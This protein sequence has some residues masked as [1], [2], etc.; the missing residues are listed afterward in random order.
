MRKLFSV[1]CVF[2]GVLPSACGGSAS[3]SV[4]A[5]GGIE[6]CAVS[7]GG[8]SDP[9]AAGGGTGALSVSTARECQWTAASDVS[10]LALS[11]VSGQGPSSISVSAAANRSTASRRST[12]TVNGQRVDVMQ[13]AATCQITVSPQALNVD[14]D[15]G[16]PSLSLTTQ[17]F[18]AWSASSRATWVT[19]GG[20]G[21]GTGPAG[22]SL[23]VAPNNGPA[24]TAIVDV[25]GHEISV[26]QAAAP[27]EC[28]FVIAPPSVAV[29]AGGTTTTI[30]VTGPPA[31]VWAAVTEAP[32]I[33]VV[34][35]STGGGSGSVALQVATNSGP[36]RTGQVTVAGRPLTVTQAAAA[37]NCSYSVAPVTASAG[38]TGGSLTF[39]VTAG[40]SCAWSAV[41]T[42]P[43]LTVSSN[44]NGAGNGPVT[45][46]VAANPG[47][48]RTGQLLIAGSTVRVD[49]AAAAP[50]PP[51]CSFAIG[52]TAAQ[53]PAAGGTTSTSVNTTAGCSW[54]ASSAASW[55]VVTSGATGSGPGTVTF[56][57]DANTGSERTGTATAAGLTFTVTQPAA[58]CAFSI[59]PSAHDAPAAGGKTT[60]AVS[61]AGGCAWSTTGAPAWVSV[62]NGNGSGNGTVTLDMQPNGGAARAATILIAGESF[63]VNQAGGCSVGIDPAGHSA[64]AEAGTTTVTVTTS[65]GCAWSTTGVPSWITV[66]NGSGSG[67]GIVSLAIQANS[68]PARSATLQIGGQSFTVNQEGGCSVAIAPATYSPGAGGGST[69][70]AVTTAGGCSWSTIGAPAWIS[71]TDGSGSGDGA[72][73][74]AVEPN[75]S[76]PRSATLS[77]GGQS[78]TVN[79]E[80]GCSFSIAPSGFAPGSEGGTTSV[81]VT[82]AGD[83][84]WTTAGAPDWVTVTDGSG[85]GSGSVSITVQPSN[86]PARSATFTIAG[87]SFTVDQGAA[88]CTATVTPQSLQVDSN[89]QIQTITV[90][91]ATHCAWT[92]SVTSKVGFFRIG[93]G[94][95]GT[96]PGA[97]VVEIDR[98]PGNNVRTGTLLVAGTTVTITQSR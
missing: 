1:L 89:E 49:Q 90:D 32:W 31:C 72:V 65:S 18:C 78:F 19:V 80:G 9:I 93:S 12:V 84:A 88:G 10:W 70:V 66:T 37:P 57:A 29:G 51:Q 25:G 48:A 33:S 79:Q 54:S 44:V 15:G 35:S 92:A 27:V 14:S 41:S 46:Q 43:W 81:A 26:L 16:T 5:P 39:T 85:T 67:N 21:N 76:P 3:N 82:T 50:Q 47:G 6:R 53:V 75:Y 40:S 61:T 96:G 68:G 95:S 87:Q 97:V 30:I 34:G 23:I 24:R 45:V 28:T 52:P 56:T 62:T 36:E 38:A 2:A 22:V 11:P 94:T 4:T 86:G 69:S 98:L 73:L 83:C 13:E 58:A 20:P 8:P 55:L 64:G 74:L 17:D 42:T 63:T 71:V 91:I 59:N 60:V 77:I 7:L